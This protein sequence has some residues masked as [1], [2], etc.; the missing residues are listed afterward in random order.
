MQV[1]PRTLA[2]GCPAAVKRELRDDEVAELND[3]IEIYLE[4]ARA[5]AALD[6]RSAGG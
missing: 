3:N 1:P 4:L 6:R 5:H 2:M